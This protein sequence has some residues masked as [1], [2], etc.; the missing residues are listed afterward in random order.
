[1]KTLL[2][3]AAL[4]VACTP[5]ERARLG[6][7]VISQIDAIGSTLAQAVGWCEDHGADRAAV[8]DARKAIQEKDLGAA[9]E[10]IHVILQKSAESG[11]KIPVEVVALVE[12][13]RGALAAQAIQDGMRAL[14]TGGASSRR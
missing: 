9:I 10:R 5:A 12:T 6:V 7:P 14:S 1:M 13:A 8:D 4:S 3:I 2:L 11:E